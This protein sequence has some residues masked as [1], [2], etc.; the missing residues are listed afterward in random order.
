MTITSMYKKILVAVDVSSEAHQV[1]QQARGLA[2]CFDAT[3]QLIH[4][5]EPVALNSPYELTPDLPIEMQHVQVERA[6]AFLAKLAM[7]FDLPDIRQE[8]RLGSTKRNILETAETE[9]IDVI[10]MGTHG[11]HGIGLLLGSTATSVLHG[12]PC[13]VY[14]VRIK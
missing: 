10:V 4:V 9:K 6:K 2:K 8:V 12:T 7:D 5:I 3:L 1:M 13:D 14:T 11:R